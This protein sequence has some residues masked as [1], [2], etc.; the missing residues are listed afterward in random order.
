MIRVNEA[1]WSN[2]IAWQFMRRYPFVP[3][4]HLHDEPPTRC[5]KGTTGIPPHRANTVYLMR[6]Q[7]NA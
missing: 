3:L 2:H 4:C 6:E 5:R 7:S 1:T